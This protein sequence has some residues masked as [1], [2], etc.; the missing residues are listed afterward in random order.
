MLAAGLGRVEMVRALLTAG[1]DVN[2]RT[3]D[4]WTALSM[5]LS[6][7]S[8]TEHEEVVRLLKEHGAV[9]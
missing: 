8:S 6:H 5:A 1:A 2:A 7:A 4:N 3:D 9:D